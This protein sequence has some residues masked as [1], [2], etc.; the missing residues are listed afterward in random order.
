MK[1]DRNPLRSVRQIKTDQYKACQEMQAHSESLTGDLTQSE[2]K[3]LN[4]CHFD[5]ELDHFDS[6]VEHFATTYLHIVLG[7]P[8]GTTFC[9]GFLA[10]LLRCSQAVILKVI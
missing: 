8:G 6:V 1:T 4:T 3:S 9:M 7:F 5:A 10:W 2:S